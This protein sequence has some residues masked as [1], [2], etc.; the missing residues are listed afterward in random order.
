VI[1]D[2]DTTNF[3]ATGWFSTVQTP[4]VAS[5]SALAL[6]SST[7][8]DGATGISVSANQTM[9]FNNAL[10]SDALYNILLVK[11]SDGTTVTETTGYPSID[12]TRKIITLNPAASL[13]AA[14]AYI[15]FYGVKDI[16]G[17]YLQGA[18]NF[19]TA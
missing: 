11:A 7:P 15:I 1:G 9:T 6:S 19:T 4:S 14:T 5:V 12:A 3:S 10:N 2:T 13:S 18:V 8:T 17:Q 16:Y